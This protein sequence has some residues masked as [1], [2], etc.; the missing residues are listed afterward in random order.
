MA[1]PRYLTAL[2][3][4]PLHPFNRFFA[5]S[6]PP[7][8][9]HAFTRTLSL[10]L[11]C[12]ACSLVNVV[13]AV[14]TGKNNRRPCVPFFQPLSGVGRCTI[15][16]VVAVL[17][18]NTCTNNNVSVFLSVITLFYKVLLGCLSHLLCQFLPVEQDILPV[19]PS[20]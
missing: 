5:R 19:V 11:C 18:Q 8:Y 12:V 20:Y 14:V 7:H 13:V 15:S 6:H 1:Y 9:S 10:S 4:P 2:L 17:T 16:Y 3:L